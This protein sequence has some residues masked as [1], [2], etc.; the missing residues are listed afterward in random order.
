MTTYFNSTYIQDDDVTSTRRNENA[1]DCVHVEVPTLDVKE[2]DNTAP[3]D[4]PD[5]KETG[6]TTPQD[7]STYTLHEIEYSIDVKTR[8]L[9]GRTVKRK[10]LKEIRY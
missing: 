2:T 5:V 3:Q 10:I 7:G 8:P 1:D 9:C 4:D 6:K